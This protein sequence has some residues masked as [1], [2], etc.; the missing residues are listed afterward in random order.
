MRI[1]DRWGNQLF[2][3]TDM[4][5]GVEAE[6]WDGRFDGKFMLPGVYVYVT[7]LDFEGISEV[8]TGEVTIIR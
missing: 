2:E 1:F 6:G 5:P 7:E 3:R 4:T 8:I